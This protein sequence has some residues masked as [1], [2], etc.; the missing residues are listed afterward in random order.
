[1]E[2][3]AHA[4]LHAELARSPVYDLVYENDGVRIYRIDLPGD[5]RSNV[6]SLRRP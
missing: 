1:M 6:P 2:Q 4:G 5:A 3:F